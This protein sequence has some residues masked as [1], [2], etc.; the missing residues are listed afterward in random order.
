MRIFLAFFE[1]RSSHSAL[2]T[3]SDNWGEQCGVKSCKNQSNA[4]ISIMSGRLDLCLP[5]GVVLAVFLFC[6]PSLVHV[7][8]Q[9]WKWQIKLC[10]CQR[11][12]MCGLEGGWQLWGAIR[13]CHIA[14][15]Q[16]FFFLALAGMTEENNGR[17]A[18]SLMWW[19]GSGIWRALFCQ[20]SHSRG[21]N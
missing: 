5:A 13:S 12:D 10:G 2:V 18:P 6:P 19:R 21:L 7:H 16:D 15:K 1:L 20:L 8:F 11:D 17:R 4:T 14:T 9:T 3:P